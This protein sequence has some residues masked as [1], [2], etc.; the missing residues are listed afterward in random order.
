LDGR[1]SAETSGFSLTF[2]FDVHQAATSKN[3][4]LESG[5]Y[6]VP[7]W[8]GVLVAMLDQHFIPWSTTSILPRASCSS[9]GI[10]GM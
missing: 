9:G 2:H 5:T 10:P 6:D 7:R 1:T 4:A 8:V 3:R